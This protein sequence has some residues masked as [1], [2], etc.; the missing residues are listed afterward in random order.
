[1]NKSTPL[2]TKPIKIVQLNVQRKKHIVTQLLNNSATDIDVLLIQ[3]PAWSFIGRDPTSGADILGPVALQGWS[4]LLPVTSQNADTPRPRTMTYYRPR[5]DFSIVLRTDLL[6]DRDIQI[7][8]IVQANHLVLCKA[9]PEAVSR[10][11][12]SPNRPGQAGL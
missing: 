10:A 5:N 4:I 8:E 3:E 2:N 9:R 12:P 6:E 11:N 1:M 7:L